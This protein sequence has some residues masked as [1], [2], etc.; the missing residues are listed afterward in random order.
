MDCRVIVGR[1]KLVKTS[2]EPCYLLKT[3]VLGWVDW[4]GW[5]TWIGWLNCN[6]FTDGE[7]V[8]GQGVWRWR[9][10]L[11]EASLLVIMHRKACN[12][13]FHVEVVLLRLG[14]NGKLASSVVANAMVNPKDVNKFLGKLT[15]KL[16][17]KDFNFESY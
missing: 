8:D 3:E 10:C 16:K 12:E 17:P 2:P 15:K 7:V 11:G 14:K 13:P 9:L 5:C 6:G 1:F 4:L